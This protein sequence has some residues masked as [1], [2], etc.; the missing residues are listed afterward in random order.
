MGSRVRNGGKGKKRKDELITSFY[1]CSLNFSRDNDALK[2]WKKER[3]NERTKD[4][5][6]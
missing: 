6:I 2:K 1:Q 4:K 3:N 5:P